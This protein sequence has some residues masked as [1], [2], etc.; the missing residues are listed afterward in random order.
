MAP[1]DESKVIATRTLDGVT[2]SGDRTRIVVSLGIPYVWRN[3]FRC[4]VRVTGLDY[5][6]TP[7]DIGGWDAIQALLLAIRCAAG[8]LEDFVTRGGRIFYPDTDT[9]YDLSDF[10]ISLFGTAQT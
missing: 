10:T 3:S 6:Y 2:P 9:P 4:P 7:P 1:L 5:D 8:L